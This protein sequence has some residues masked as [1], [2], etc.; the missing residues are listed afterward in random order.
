MDRR[1]F[2]RALA[3]CVAADS[4]R[5]DAQPSVR[6]IGY[7][8]QGSAALNKPYLDALR[9]GLRD[10]GWDNES[11][12]I[13][14]RFAEGKTER[15]PALATELVQGKVDLIATWSTPA[16]LAAKQATRTIPIVIGF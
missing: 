2:L 8:D 9:Q 16:A 13:E 11:V 12:K 14:A 6:R 3:C 1:A 15:L 7:L 10:L 5:V 4:L